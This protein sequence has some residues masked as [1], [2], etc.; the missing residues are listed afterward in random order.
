MSKDFT[1]I[2]WHDAVMSDGEQVSRKD[3]ES[4]YKLIRG[5]SV[6]HFVFETDELVALATDNF[7]EHDQYRQISLYPKSSIESIKTVNIDLLEK[8]LSFQKER[9]DRDA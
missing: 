1:I 4:H 3:A 8:E 2:K 5:V 7:Y 9:G 6:G